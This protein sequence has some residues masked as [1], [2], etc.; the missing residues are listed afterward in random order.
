MLRW[1]VETN[2]DSVGYNQDIIFTDVDVDDVGYKNTQ[3]L[4]VWYIYLYLGD[5]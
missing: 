4:H 2:N 1:D 5:F 3:M